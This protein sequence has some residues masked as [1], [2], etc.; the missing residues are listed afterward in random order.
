MILIV[1][2]FLQFEIILLLI[3]FQS[4]IELIAFRLVARRDGIVDKLSLGIALHLIKSPR[5]GRD[6]LKSIRNDNTAQRIAFLVA[7]HTIEV[8]ACIWLRNH[9]SY[10]WRRISTSITDAI[11]T[12]ATSDIEKGECHHKHCPHHT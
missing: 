6:T 10:R 5:I 1:G 4:L 11:G 8:I 7:Y 2:K 9:R 12:A 3:S